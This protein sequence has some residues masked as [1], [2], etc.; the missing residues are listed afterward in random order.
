MAEDISYIRKWIKRGLSKDNKTLDFS[1]KGIDNLI[2]EELAE[3]VALPDI[4]IL[5]L[6][7][8]KIKDEGLEELANSEFF[9]PLKELWVYENKI[10]D[11]GA[12]ALAESDNVLQ[13]RYLSLYTNRIG[14]DGAIALATSKNLKNLETLDL[15]FNPGWRIQYSTRFDELTSTFRENNF[16]LLYDNPC[17]CWGIKFDVIDRQIREIDNDRR[18][19]TQYLFTIKL[20]G[21][22]ELRN[23]TVGMFLHRDF[24]DT[25]FPKTNFE[26]K[27]MKETD[28]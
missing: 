16:S 15:S 10:S 26:S 27:L 13:L 11:N 5:Y 18:D 7:T 28:F 17:K 23:R 6:H 3:N 4:E 22:G 20:R 9:E 14:D 8:N 2:A 25:S 12:V 21:L 24:E 19:Q 1:N